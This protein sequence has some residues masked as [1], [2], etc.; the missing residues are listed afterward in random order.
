MNDEDALDTSGAEEI[1]CPHCHYKYESSWEFMLGGDGDSGVIQCWGC[2]E[3]F[4]ATK[5]VEVTYATR[6]VEPCRYLDNHG[7]DCSWAP[8]DRCPDADERCRPCAYDEHRRQRALSLLEAASMTAGDASYRA[9]EK[10]E[11]GS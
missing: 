6:P 8:G 5:H 10:P 11:V 7:M 2:D 9:L 3:K 4:F 1:V